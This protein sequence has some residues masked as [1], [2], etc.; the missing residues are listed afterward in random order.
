MGPRMGRIHEVIF[1]WQP[2]VYWCTNLIETRGTEHSM[3]RGDV[4]IRADM[5]THMKDRASGNHEVDG[6]RAARRLCAGWSA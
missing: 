3:W 2:S 5:A 6:P 1:R 4:V